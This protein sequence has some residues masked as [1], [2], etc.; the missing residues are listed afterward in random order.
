MAV[1]ARIFIGDDLYRKLPEVEQT[2]YEEWRRYK[3]DWIG[4]C[5]DNDPDRDFSDELFNSL[6]EYED[7]W[8]DDFSNTGGSVYVREFSS[9][10]PNAEDRW[11]K[12]FE[13]FSKGI[14]GNQIKVKL[15]GGRKKQIRDCVIVGWEVFNTLTGKEGKGQF[16]EFVLYANS[17]KGLPSYPPPTLLDD[18]GGDDYFFDK[19][20]LA[21]FFGVEDSQ[22]LNAK[23]TASP[24]SRIKARTF[25][26]KRLTDEEK[27]MWLERAKD[28][29]GNQVKI[30]EV[31]Y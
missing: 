20:E 30:I 12:Y 29:A 22:E 14:K 26:S 4:E 5:I 24:C 6:D 18:W 16:K 2:K 23:A 19:Q 27:K 15:D 25:A 10:L 28:F 17:P 31:W 1:G 21:D 8:G 3:P 11:R 13:K 9:F 7:F